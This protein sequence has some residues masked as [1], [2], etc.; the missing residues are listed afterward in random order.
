ME[1]S[2]WFSITRLIWLQATKMTENTM[3]QDEIE[4]NDFIRKGKK[5]LINNYLIPMKSEV[6]FVQFSQRIGWY[7]LFLLLVYSVFF[8]CH[9]LL[10]DMFLNLSISFHTFYFLSTPKII[11]QVISLSILFIY[12]LILLLTFFILF[13]D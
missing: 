2:V 6:Y 9:K 8:S 12:F 7:S 5:I 4:W 10:I 11:L 1:S 13:A 3:S